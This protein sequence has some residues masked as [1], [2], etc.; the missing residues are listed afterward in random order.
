MLLDNK[1]NYD[2]VKSVAIPVG[3]FTAGTLGTPGQTGIVAGQ[4]GYLYV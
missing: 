1:F 4:S 3:N 2:A